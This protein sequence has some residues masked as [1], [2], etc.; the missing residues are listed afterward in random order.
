MRTHSHDRLTRILRLL[1]PAVAAALLLAALPDAQAGGRR[2]QRARAGKAQAQGPGHRGPGRRG[3]GRRGP[4]QRG[5]EQRGP[6]Q[7]GHRGQ[8]RPE[9]AGQHAG[10]QGQ[11]R[12]QHGRRQGRPPVRAS[13]ARTHILLVVARA[14]IRNGG[15][16]QRRFAAAALQQRAAGVA[17]RR[18]A[19]RA[20]LYLTRK[21]RETAREII[22]ANRAG[23]P[24]E[25]ADRPGEFDAADGAGIASFLDAARKRR[26]NPRMDRSLGKSG[27]LLSVAAR[28]GKKGGRGS[29]ALRRAAV[30]QRAARTAGQRGQWKVA[31][32]LTGKS[33][34]SAREALAAN[35]VAEPASTADEKGEFV[36]ASSADASSYVE[37]AD[38]EVPAE[39][40]EAVAESVDEAPV[41]DASKSSVDETA[42]EVD[43]ESYEYQLEA[44][45]SASATAEDTATA[46]ET[47]TAE[48]PDPAATETE[49]P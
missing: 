26:R 36:E 44:D 48:E 11:P 4:E 30:L 34:K 21:A 41:E 25:A 1:T 19:P 38:A 3:P 2:G 46:G 18:K 20:A 16:G 14:S 12:G 15:S 6:E 22:R 13:L 32:H 40:D 29:A 42:A 33:R 9:Q 7:R 17:L 31:L 24:A 27:T 8:R 23:E 47:A 35:G 49:A 43:F 37:E 10:R 28:A 45:A 39:V 5:P